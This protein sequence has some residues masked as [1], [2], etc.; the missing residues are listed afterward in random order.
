MNRNHLSYDTSSG[1]MSAH[2]STT[3]ESFGIVR[4]SSMWDKNRRHLV[5]IAETTQMITDE[6]EVQLEDDRMTIEAPL[7]S[8]EIEDGLK[9]IGFSSLRLKPGYKYTHVSSEAIDSNLIK[10]TLGYQNIP[11]SA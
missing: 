7:V 4:T 8:A 2:F 6:I 10:V 11:G 5:L 9:V 1:K 3:K